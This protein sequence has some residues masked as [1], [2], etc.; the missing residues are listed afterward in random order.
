LPMTSQPSLSSTP[1][2]ARRTSSPICTT[3]TS[4]VPGADR[5]RSSSYL[6]LDLR[7][8]CPARGFPRSHGPSEA[9]LNGL[10]LRVR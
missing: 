4:V 3:C 5:W 8:P 2:D 7:S 9:L 1:L 6:S 10:R